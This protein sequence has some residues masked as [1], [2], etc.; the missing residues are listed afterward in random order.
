VWLAIFGVVISI[1]GATILTYPGIK[2]EDERFGR[3]VK[4]GQNI[5]KAINMFSREKP[6]FW[7]DRKIY[8]V[9]L[10]VTVV[11]AILTILDLL[12]LISS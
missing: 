2:P 3:K 9:G 4:P 7:T 12:G 6:P 1:I 11:G 5:Q 8:A 10:M